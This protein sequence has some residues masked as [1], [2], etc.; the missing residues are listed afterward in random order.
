M[1]LAGELLFNFSGVAPCILR[2]FL[3]DILIRQVLVVIEL[4]Y[5]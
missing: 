2:D 3:L 4:P 5:K 1:N